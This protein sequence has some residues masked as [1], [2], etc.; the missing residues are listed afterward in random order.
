VELCEPLES[1]SA[2]YKGAKMLLVATLT[3]IISYKV[4]RIDN[5]LQIGEA[6]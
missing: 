5:D 2:E 1:L 6:G 4:I 3:E